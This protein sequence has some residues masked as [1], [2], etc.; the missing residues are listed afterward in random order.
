[1]T[2]GVPDITSRCDMQRKAGTGSSCFSVFKRE[3]TFPEAPPH[4]LSGLIGHG[5]SHD[6]GGNC[7]CPS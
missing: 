2:A 6:V 3:E 4:F 1:M 5:G 7:W